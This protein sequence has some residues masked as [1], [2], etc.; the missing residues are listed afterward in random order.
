MKLLDIL[1]VLLL[2]L[3]NTGCGYRFL[4]KKEQVVH[5]KEG[6]ILFGYHDTRTYF[7]EADVSVEFGKAKLKDAFVIT[8]VLDS[9]EMRCVFNNAN[10]FE[11]L[12]PGTREKME[13]K[14]SPVSINYNYNKKEIL[15]EETLVFNSNHVIV[16]PY[17]F[18]SDLRII[19][20]NLLS[21]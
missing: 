3:Y 17:Y 5:K 1:L 15:G 6:F 18:L 19:E 2:M 7:I 13:V 20:V 9:S 8:H 10:K 21:E 14:I 4:I 11:L 12:V 16:L